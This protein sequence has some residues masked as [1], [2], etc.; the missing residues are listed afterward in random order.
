MSISFTDLQKFLFEEIEKTRQ[1][2]KASLIEKNAKL[3]LSDAFFCGEDIIKNKKF[4]EALCLAITDIK[5]IF[6]NE[7]IHVLDAGSGTGIL[8]ILALLGWAD[9]VTFI[10]A[11]TITLD[12]S[13]R[14]IEK[15]W[16]LEKSRFYG[17][18]A[19]KINLTQKF[20]L[21]VSETITIDF[22]RE[23][24]YSIIS[25]L[26]QFLTPQAIII[27]EGFDITFS[28]QDSHKN[29]ISKNTISRISLWEFSP[30]EEVFLEETEILEISWSV[31]LYADILVHSG[32]CV[33]FFNTMIIENKALWNNFIW[34]KD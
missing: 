12:W 34:N 18:D 1:Q 13:K 26:K 6:P 2:K 3:Q 27:P 23:D 7:E 31:K 22:Q 28:Q 8:W 17:E 25:H 21:L 20:H 5:N 19:T 24:F 15:L 4:F 14:F 9:H 33:S 29:I 11:N 30:H 10:E 32:S 16:L